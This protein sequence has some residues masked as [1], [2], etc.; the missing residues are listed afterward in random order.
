MNTVVSMISSGRGAAP[1]AK[2]AVDARS[3]VSRAK[4]GKRM[5][6]RLLAGPCRTATRPRLRQEGAS[7]LTAAGSLLL[8]VDVQAGFARAVEEAAASRIHRTRLLEAASRLDVPVIVS[9][10]YPEGLGHTDP[11]LLPLLTAGHHPAQARL[12]LLARA[13]TAPGDRDRR[14]PA[15]RGRRHGNPCLRPADR[16]RSRHR[17]LFHPPRRRRR[18]LQAQPRTEPSASSACAGTA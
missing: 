18:G 7:M 1:L 13:R 10:H 3:S 5:T 9:E 2:N 17:R 14:P 16:P 4:G 11:R 6:V 8:I 12:L 15:D